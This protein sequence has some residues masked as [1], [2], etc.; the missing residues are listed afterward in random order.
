MKN[1]YNFSQVAAVYCAEIGVEIPCMEQY[2]RAIFNNGPVE[3]YEKEIIETIKGRYD[4]R[5]EFFPEY[6]Q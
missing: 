3:E 5:S 2:L 6:K 1:K 4:G